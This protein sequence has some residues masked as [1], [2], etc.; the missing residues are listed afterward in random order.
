MIETILTEEQKIFRQTLREFGKRDIEPHLK[1][2]A[3]KKGYP[4]ELAGK[5]A[6][7][8]VMGLTIPEE[9]GGIGGGTVD[10]VICM[11]ELCR[12]GGFAPLTHL[13][14]SRAISEYASE[15][16]KRKY[17]PPL[18]TGE[19][20]GAYAQTEPGAGSDATAMRTTAVLE[21]D[22]YVVN[23]TKCF[24]SNAEVADVFVVLAKTDPSQRKGG[25][26][27]FIVERDSP[28]LSVGK[29]EDKMGL[30]ASPTNEI[31]FDNCIV[32]K[33][34]LMVAEGEAFKLMMRSFNAERC[35]NSAACLGM[36]ERAFER[37]FA[38]AQQREAFDRPIIRFQGIQWMFADM[39]TQIEAARLLIYNA[40]WRI[41][42]KLPS[43]K[44]AAM[45]KCFSNEM[46]QR[47]INDAMQI[48]G[49]YGYMQEYEVERLWRDARGLAFGGGTPQILRNRI[50]A[51]LI[52]Y[53]L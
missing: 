41:D 24:I 35:G 28:G 46:A 19:K 2:Y 47:V 48:H 16:L 38:Y 36:A 39:A 14:A 13:G 32:P 4:S 25:I 7:I 3:D 5:L 37:A 23:G 43:A 29:A 27:V 22:H 17:L 33:D 40:A 31:V 50:A 10:V 12:A 42:R 45:A 20:L 6:G 11:E 1:E 52:R 53:T 15:G 8:G 49:G 51:E 21:G 26:S 30:D 9:Y 34:N 18:A 44:E